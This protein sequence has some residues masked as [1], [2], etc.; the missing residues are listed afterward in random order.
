MTF[1]TVDITP[2]VEVLLDEKGAGQPTQNNKMICD[3]IYL[4]DLKLIVLS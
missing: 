3:H 4:L 2:D 1:F